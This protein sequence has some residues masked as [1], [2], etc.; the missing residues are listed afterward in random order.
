MMINPKVH[1]FMQR[2]IGGALM[3]QLQ[4]TYFNSCNPEG[5]MSCAMG[6]MIPK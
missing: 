2:K 3:I 5:H 6:G 4:V 1:Y